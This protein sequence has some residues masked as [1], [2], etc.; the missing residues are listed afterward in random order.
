MIREMIREMIGAT[1]SIT[2]TGETGEMLNILLVVATI[3][4]LVI[5]TELADRATIIRIMTILR[6][7]ASNRNKL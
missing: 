1:L 7:T 6:T 3:V 5:P 2:Q 4:I